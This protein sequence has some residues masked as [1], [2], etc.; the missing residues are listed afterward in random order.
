MRHRRGQR[1]D[2]VAEPRAQ[3]SPTQAASPPA[4][5]RFVR[6]PGTASARL[7]DP[8]PLGPRG[9]PKRTAPGPDD[10]AWSREP[11]SPDGTRGMVNPP[12]L[13][14]TPGGHCDARR[15]VATMVA[16]NGARV[17]RP[18]ARAVAARGR[19]ANPTPC[20]AVNRMSAGWAP[21]FGRTG[22]QGW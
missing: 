2:T 10:P 20:W 22:H 3:D 7:P 8:G 19:A 13:S 11:V 18:H 1:C 9:K 21:S 14:L 6:L 12:A 17:D 5:Q 15:V 4:Y 16:T